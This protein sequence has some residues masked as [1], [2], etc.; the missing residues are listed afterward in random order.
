MPSYTYNTVNHPI[1]PT[2]G[3]SLFLSTA[4]RGQLPG[5]QREHRPADARLQILPAG[6]R[7]TRATSWHST[8]WARMLTGYGGK[9]APPFSRTYIG[10]E[11]DIRGFD[12]WGISPIAFV[13]SEATINVL[14]DDG[15]A[16]H[17]EGNVE[18][19]PVPSPRH[20]E[21]SRSIS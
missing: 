14:N 6:A 12:I 19:R 13:P 8:C 1:T 21:R 17:A 16:A 3:K 11:Q 2:G 20:H 7:G 18:R 4:V 9:V 10:G 15:I 5:R